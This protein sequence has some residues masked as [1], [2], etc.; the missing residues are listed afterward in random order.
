MGTSSQE[1]IQELRLP[2]KKSHMYPKLLN[3]LTKIHFF[4]EA[5]LGYY[6]YVLS[7]STL[8][9]QIKWLEWL[10]R[11]IKVANA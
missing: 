7:Y 11:I 9:D 8:L 10:D 6:L 4:I 1:G 2:H 5:T 3:K